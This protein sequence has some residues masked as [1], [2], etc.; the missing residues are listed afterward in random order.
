MMNAKSQQLDE[1]EWMLNQREQL[2]REKEKEKG[3]TALE[4]SVGLYRLG[5][6]KRATQ[7]FDG[8]RLIGSS[9]RVYK[10][11]IGTV[12]V[13]IKRMERRESNDNN[14]QQE[15][16]NFLQVVSTASSC[17]HPNIVPLIGFCFERNERCLVY[18]LMKGGSLE[19]RLASSQTKTLDCETRVRISVQIAEAIAFLHNTEGGERAVIFHQNINP[20]KILLDSHD[21]ARLTDVGTAMYV[22]GSVSEATTTTLSSGY[23]DPGYVVSGQYRAWSDVYSF[24][25]VMLRL[26]TGLP[27]IEDGK[28]L[29]SRMKALMRGDET[30]KN[31]INFT[32]VTS[33]HWPTEVASEYARIALDCTSLDPEEGPTMREVVNKLTTIQQQHFKRK[34]TLTPTE[35]Q[36]CLCVVRKIECVLEPCSHIVTCM[37]CAMDLLET[38]GRCP[39]CHKSVNELSNV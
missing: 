33:G 39:L 29:N 9:R 32:D 6:I 3:Q 25:V 12:E 16:I 15:E 38:A 31:A 19:E 22:S 21:N 4:S 18:P 10:A 28:R 20:Y 14:K 30:M 17:K 23:I 8:G 24:G 34:L 5:Q 2:I 13:A 27:A 37:D 36:C 26:W 11:T 7:G 35:D 1:R